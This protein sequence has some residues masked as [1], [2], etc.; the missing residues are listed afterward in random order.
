MILPKLHNLLL[1]GLPNL[2]QFSSRNSVEFPT[3]TQLSVKDCPKL[4]H[5]WKKN[6]S[7]V[8]VFRNLKSMKLDNCSSLRYIFTPS[9]VSGFMQLQE[10]EIINCA[11][12]KKSSQLKQRR[13]QPLIRLWKKG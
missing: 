8:M 12:V 7:Q 2:T 3:L 9:V 13:M 5:I 6:H 4:K 11:I 10:F 1:I